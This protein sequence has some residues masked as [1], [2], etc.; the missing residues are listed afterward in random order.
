MTSMNDDRPPGPILL[1]DGLCG[2]C[3]ATVQVIL[4][5]D[6]RGLMRFAALQSGY[7]EAVKTR[8]PEVRGVDS[9]VLIER[10]PGTGEERVL[11]RSNAALRVAAYLGGWWRL[12]VVFGLVPQAVRDGV[13]DAFAR[14][15]YRLFGKYDRCLVPAADVRARF[16]DSE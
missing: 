3:N 8:H 4:R 6:R 2:F 9:I 14:H 16:I 12:L 11:L 10:V 15:R 1:Y 13:Y 7:G 5:H